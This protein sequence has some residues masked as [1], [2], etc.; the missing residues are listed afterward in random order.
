MSE[1]TAP[2]VSLESH[3]LE[4][5]IDPWGAQLS[6]LRDAHG[7]DLLWDGDPTVWNGRAPLLFPIVGALAGGS[8][9]LGANTYAL[10]RHGFARGRAFEL[11]ESAAAR[12][13]FRLRDDAGTLALYP[14]HFEL[15]V[16][17]EVEH[18][19]LTLTAHVV[20]RGSEPMPASFGYHPAFRWPLPF[21]HERSAHAIEFAVE[22]P[23]PIRRLDA[24]GLL[25]AE[26]HPTPIRDRRLELNDAL[27]ADDAA[28]FDDIRSRHVTYGAPGGPRIRVSYP[29]APYL[30]LWSKPDAPFVCIEPW[31]GIADP[32]G[33]TG[34]FTVKPGVFWVPP[35]NERTIV[36]AVTLL[37]ESTAT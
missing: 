35:G 16:H 27:F 37:H 32:A 9:R 28:I 19:T 31:H 13:V 34:D 3:G 33:F 7:R 10:S 6:R 20:N 1:H 22:E 11:V 2:W 21:G 23:A 8:Y 12:A 36:M 26:R 4:A 5:Q 17:F 30:G 14:F 29:D 25:T 24:E 15:R 18:S